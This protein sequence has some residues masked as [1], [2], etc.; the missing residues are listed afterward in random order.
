MIKTDNGEEPTNRSVKAPNG[1]WGRGTVD[2]DY[3]K[4]ELTVFEN[5]QASD[6]LR[7]KFRVRGNTSATG[8]KKPYKI[9]LDSPADML[10]RSSDYEDT[11]W[12]LLNF[13]DLNFVVGQEVARIC[14]ME[15]QPCYKL[16]NLIVNGDWK[17]SYIL[18]ESVKQG[19]ARVDVSQDG[20]IVENDAYWW[21]TDRL[22]FKTDRQFEKLRYTI[23]YPKSEGIGS[24]RIKQ[25]RDFF[26]DVEKRVYDADPDLEEY[27]DFQSFASWLLTHDILGNRDAA[28]S[29]MF[30]SKTDMKSSKLKIGPVWD[31]DMIFK[32]RRSW[33]HIHYMDYMYMR[34][35]LK[36]DSFRSVYCERIA[37][38]SGTL[39]E[40]VEGFLEELQA[41][42]G[43]S[44][45]KSWELNASRW[46]QEP[47]DFEQ[48]RK[49]AVDWIYDQTEWIRDRIN[50]GEF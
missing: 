20:F 42:S 45:Q 12:I 22:N 6:P 3:V 25:I 38:G 31:Y 36:N 19:S 44:I 16:V 30:L 15:W 18:T 34:T 35:L 9:V 43:E 47:G 29:N 10:G 49:A 33:S 48:N 14:R 27:V 39:P 23:H 28:G 2:N 46:G 7:M 11:D 5:R 40:T 24:E 41:T 13:T 21:N 50:S 26:V 32:T 1:Y 4:G 8:K 37:K 17:G